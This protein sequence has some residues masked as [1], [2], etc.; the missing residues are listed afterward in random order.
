MNKKIK[1]MFIYTLIILQTH[2]LFVKG[3]TVNCTDKFKDKQL[4]AVKYK[5]N[6]Q[7]GEFKDSLQ[8]GRRRIPMSPIEEEKCELW[9]KIE[10]VED[11]DCNKEWTIKFSEELDGT[12]YLDDILFVKN[13]YNRRFE[14]YVRIKDKKTF[15]IVP[16]EPYEEGVT[17]ILYIKKNTMS[18]SGEILK[19]GIKMPF[20]IKCDEC[21]RQN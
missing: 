20:K 7:Q 21:K 10:L 19:K 11:V 1:K 3:A 17:Y 14:T 8:Y 2:S 12:Y 6:Y 13:Q 18:K 5:N 9:N 4:V 16:K 15:V